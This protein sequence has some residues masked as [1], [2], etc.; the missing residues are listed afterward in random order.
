MAPPLLVLRVSFFRGDSVWRKLR[1]ILGVCLR[2][3]MAWFQPYFKGQSSVVWPCLPEM[4]RLQSSCLWRRKKADC[5]GH[6]EFS[7]LLLISIYKS[8][9]SSFKCCYLFIY[10]CLCQ[11]FIAAFGLSLVDVHR[12]WQKED[13]GF[14]CCGAWDLGFSSCSSCSS[15]AQLPCRK[16]NLP[17]PRIEPCSL[18]SQAD[19]QPLDHQGSPQFIF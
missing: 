9:L 10:F 19:S 6:I 18:H 5:G 11:L 1:G 15:R 16:Y 4:K 14:S 7:A 12:N 2:S 8:S 13:N 17:E 3:G